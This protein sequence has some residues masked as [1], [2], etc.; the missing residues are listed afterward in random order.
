MTL[1]LVLLAI[2]PTASADAANCKVPTIAV[3]GFPE[4]CFWYSYQTV[5]VD[6]DSQNRICHMNY[7]RLFTPDSMEEMNKVEQ[8][9]IPPQYLKTREGAYFVNYIAKWAV[10]NA[11]NSREDLIY[12]T[13]SGPHQMMPTD[14]W[15]PGEPDFQDNDEM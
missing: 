7:S 1:A 8:S 3:D 13:Y 6:W 14:L 5:A 9:L 11:E 12:V 2:L 10:W 4:K 15:A